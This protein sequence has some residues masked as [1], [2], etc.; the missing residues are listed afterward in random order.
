MAINIKYIKDMMLLYAVTDRA[1]VG[2]QTLMEQVEDAIKGGITCVQLREK[3]LDQEA[4]L[5][6]AM[7]MK[8]LCSRYG[9]PLIINDNVEIAIMQMAYM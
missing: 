8:A 5:A 2:K 3:E 6:E 4:F 9:V 7:E 1:W